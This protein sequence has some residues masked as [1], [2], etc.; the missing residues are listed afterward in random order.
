VSS[1]RPTVLVAAKAPAPGR[2]KTRLVPP[3]TPAQAAALARALLLDTLDSCREG[4]HPPH[5]LAP[6]ADVDAIAALAGA[7]PVLAQEGRGLADALR[8][9]MARHLPAGPVAI[10]ASDVPGLP[11]GA[12]DAAF[13]ALDEGA[14]LVLGPSHDGGYW[15][16]A[17][18][19]YHEAP[20]TEIPW[21]TPACAAVT[22]ERAGAAGL[23][24]E[25]LELWR[26]VD[27]SVDLAALGRADLAGAPRTAALVD[28]L[29]SAGLVPDPPP[30]RLASS[31]LVAGNPWRALLDDRLLD[32]DG[33]AC[34]YTYL[35]VPRAVFCV[36][37]TDD[38]EV[39]LVRQYRHPVRDW[40]LE[41]PAGSVADGETPADAARRELR[42]ETGGAARTWRHLA[43]FWPSTGH[44]S[45]RADAFLAE[46][47]VLG[48]PA[49]EAGEDLE[50]VRMAIPEALRIAR[51]GGFSDGQTALAL[52]LAAPHLEGS[53]GHPG[54]G[55]LALVRPVPE[56]RDSAR[57]PLVERDD[58]G[59]LVRALYPS[60][61]DASN[62]TKLLANAPD[63]LAVL[64][65][66]LAQVM[67]A[68]TVDLATKEI[69]VLRVSALNACAYCVPTHTV[70]AARAGLPA[71]A[72]AALCDPSRP[73]PP[74][75]LDDRQRAVV[76]LCDR[77]VR[78]AASVDG[79]LLASLHAWFA[80]HEIVELTV[81]AGAITLL[82][83][84]ASAFDLPLDARTLAAL[85]TG[86]P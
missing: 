11:A 36:A 73:P 24:V 61:G 29:R 53:H 77:L 43:T 84:V 71:G 27:T 39:V 49:P 60:G 38:G 3:L 85:G 75:A 57:L 16:I 62:I 51:A 74:G 7:A 35:A 64:A 56:P 32:A 78:D 12:L 8:R 55:P 44:L 81:L 79:A 65:P 80:D 42:E 59:L 14:D 20:F 52:L 63:T 45:M 19:G 13:R 18:R 66:L 54:E 48:E 67:N 86:A 33:R 31:A 1:P 2:S 23:R 15:L 28:E 41:V 34:S 25:R 30:L 46:G 50:V 72:V 70:A 21:S 9:A 40:T 10:V 47:V 68:S 5:L 17:M 6:A 83:Y 37:A 22:A 4:G 26:D 76:E 82:N 58:A 69:V